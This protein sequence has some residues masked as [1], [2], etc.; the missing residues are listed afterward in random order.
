MPISYY[1]H[2]TNKLKMITER[3]PST[4]EHCEVNT[5]NHAKSV[6]IHSLQNRTD[7]HPNYEA[8]VLLSYVQNLN[9]INK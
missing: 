9:S 6:T 4:P 3:I 5:K 7:R 1:L 8:V 2:F